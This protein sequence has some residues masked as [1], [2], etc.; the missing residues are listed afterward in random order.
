[1]NKQEWHEIYINTLI[2]H[3]GFTRKEAE[4]NVAAGQPFDYEF[5][6]KDAAWEEIGYWID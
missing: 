2:E 1:M 3:G 6:P 4:E 5:D